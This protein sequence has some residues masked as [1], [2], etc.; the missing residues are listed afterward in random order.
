L[1]WRDELAPGTQDAVPSAAQSAGE[2]E[3]QEPFRLR[4]VRAVPVAPESFPDRQGP[5][6]PLVHWAGLVL[7][8][9]SAQQAPE[10]SR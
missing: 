7:L 4:N 10:C 8:E 2:V 9:L 1:R 5:A 3:A 6:R